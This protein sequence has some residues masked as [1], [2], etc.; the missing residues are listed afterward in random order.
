M[1]DPAVLV[2]VEH[3][4]LE[5]HG[6]VGNLQWLRPRLVDDLLLGVDQLEHRVHVDKSLADGPIDHAEHVERPKQLHQQRVDQYQVADRQVA[7][8]PAIDAERHRP[9]HRQI[10][11]D[12]LADIE[13]AERI[14]RLYRGIGPV[15]HR[16]VI[17]FALAP[18]GGEIFDRLVVQEG[19][20]RPADHPCVHVIHP[21]PERV[22]PVGHLAGE[23][24][25]DRDHRR[26]RRDQTKAE[27][28][29][30]DDQ[31]RGQL[32]HRRSNIEQ[33]EIEHHVDALGPALDDLGNLAG[34][35][36]QMES[37]R[38]AVQM[39]EDIGRQPPRCLLANLLEHDVAQI[40][41]HHLSEPRHAIGRDQREQHRQFGAE[42]IVRHAVDHRLVEKRH[43]KN[44]R[45]GAQHQKS[46]NDDAHPEARLALGPEIGQETFQRR[47]HRRVD[48]A[49]G[50]II[51]W[52]EAGCR[53]TGGESLSGSGFRDLPPQKL[54]LT[55]SR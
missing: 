35:A 7:L 3:H 48:L 19:V 32:D 37:Q 46:G 51:R 43:G 21:R 27:L 29:L 36:A 40:V 42:R 33:Q 31:Y 18:L 25:I 24:D 2:I 12:G 54:P 39:G 20:D 50:G 55:V 26:G 17:A 22:S 52:H 15:A 44:R 5:P 16:L 13:Q 11:D 49:L 45:L 47:D 23:D 8:L 28:D 34:A 6:A 1:Q 41:E 4:I 9:D 53:D 14:F 10:G 38:Q 30:E